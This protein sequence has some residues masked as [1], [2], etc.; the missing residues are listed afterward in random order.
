MERP[1][2]L[3]PGKPAR[4]VLGLIAAAIPFILLSLLLAA[5][6]PR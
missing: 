3:R 4:E 5:G 6:L 1:V 2:I